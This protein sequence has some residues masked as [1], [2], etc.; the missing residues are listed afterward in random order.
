M[1][2]VQRDD[3]YVRNYCT[4]SLARD[5]TDARHNYGQYSPGDTRASIAEAWRL[6]V[7]DSYY[8]GR[9]YED[10]YAFNTVTFVL[11]NADGAARDVAVIGTFSDLVNPIPMPRVGDSISDSL[12]F[13][14]RRDAQNSS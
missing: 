5:N 10:S 8:N 12:F 11:A 4:K 13:G 2:V 1:T 3:A 9:S 7:I 14:R 6:P